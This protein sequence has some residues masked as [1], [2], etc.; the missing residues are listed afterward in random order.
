MMSDRVC[1]S[2][3]RC[4]HRH[5]AHQ[6]HAVAA[7][8]NRRPRV[9]VRC[10]DGQARA[11]LDVEDTHR[12]IRWRSPPADPADQKS[13]STTA[14]VTQGESRGWEGTPAEPAPEG[15]AGAGSVLPCSL[16]PQQSDSSD[17]PALE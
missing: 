5:T 1:A 7:E 9:G 10:Q 3:L 2:K 8:A 11:T 15:T 13:P 4:S 16:Q 6:G 12:A 17:A 14:G